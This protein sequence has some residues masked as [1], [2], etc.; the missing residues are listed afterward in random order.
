[1]L[2]TTIGST[3]SDNN[4]TPATTP[5]CSCTT[6]LEP[7]SERIG[8]VT[9]SAA[10]VVQVNIGCQIVLTLG[11]E[12]QALADGEIVGFNSKILHSVSAATAERWVISWRQIKP[13][14][15]MQQLSL[16]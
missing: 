13:E 2:P 11:E 4:S 1:M 9:A 8:I 14:F 15:L 12:R 3:N 16:F 5:V 7:T 10:K 6:R